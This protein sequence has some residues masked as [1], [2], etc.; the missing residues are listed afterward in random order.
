MI[1]GSNEQLLH[2]LEYTLLKPDCVLIN[3]I[4]IFLN[5]NLLLIWTFTKDSLFLRLPKLRSIASI[6]MENI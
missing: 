2:Q 1:S 5:S 4:F 6:L 3:D